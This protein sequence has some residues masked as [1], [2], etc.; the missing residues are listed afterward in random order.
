MYKDVKKKLLS[1]AL[2]ICMVIGVVQVVPRAKAAA[3]TDE[4]GYYQ[5]EAGYATTTGTKKLKVKLVTNT[6]LFYKGSA[7]IPVVS[8]IID[9]NNQDMMSD[10]D[11]NLVCVSGDNTNVGTF[12]CTLKPTTST[13]TI[14][15]SRTEN[16]I[17][18]TIKP[19]EVNYLIVDTGAVSGETP[20]L[21]YSG[22]DVTP[23]FNTVT[24]VLGNDRV[25]LSNDQY[26]VTPIQEVG[27][28]KKCTVTLKTNSNFSNAD[29]IS[30]EVTYDVAYDLATYMKLD[31]DSLDY[32]NKDLSSSITMS[33]Y[34]K[35][36]SVVVPNVS[37]NTSGLKVLFNGLENQSVKEAGA[38]QVT[39]KPVNG[40]SSIVELN[41]NLFTGTFI[42][43]FTV[44]LRKPNAFVV[45]ATDMDTK[46]SV[47]LSS[48]TSSYM[49]RISLSETDSTGNVYP[50]NLLV[51]VD[52]KEYKKDQDYDMWC[53]NSRNDVVSPNQSGRYTLH[54][55]MKAS[56]NYD[57]EKTVAYYV[58]SGLEINKIRFEGETADLT[59][60][61]YTGEGRKIAELQVADQSQN[62]L[63]R[64]ADYTVEYWYKNGN[65]WIQ[66]NDYNDPNMISVGNKRIVVSGKNAY[67]G[68]A[69]NFGYSI[70]QVSMTDSAE[71][72]NF[73]LEL[74]SGLAY[75]YTGEDIEPPYT[76][77]YRN[78]D[79]DKRYYTARYTDNKN[80]GSAT[81]TVQANKNGPF[82]G[83]LSVNFTIDP[84][85]LADAECVG[86]DVSAVASDYSYTGKKIRRG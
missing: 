32:A 13:Y 76:F 72:I 74:D 58:Y 50:K 27:R 31:K 49:Y 6:T 63:T 70:K 20:I 52:G 29:K 47:V 22:N 43:T 25:S 11:A 28:G 84:L 37:K 81:L 61:D 7:Y 57:Y 62:K 83:S 86:D 46:K 67:K 77:K 15:Q 3:T 59:E 55:K 36:G 38:Y 10:F 69:A 14:D 45:S 34:N 26:E 66:V 4:Q 53:T 64:D 2:C 24:A 1:V 80:A 60:L 75:D 82:T 51:V 73:K 65:N 79:V 85:S 18:F 78:A 42:G 23:V 40:E 41:N 8:E 68:E 44:G 12:V 30:K 54:I 71:A 19:A 5:I 21:K 39:I 56:T 16:L 9:E 33:L 35:S 48:D 17:E